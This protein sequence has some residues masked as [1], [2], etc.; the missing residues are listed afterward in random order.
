MIKGNTETVEGRSSQ[1][2]PEEKRIIPRCQSR[3]VNLVSSSHRL[4]APSLWHKGLWCLRTRGLVWTARMVLSRIRGFVWGKGTQQCRSGLVG[5]TT[6]SHEIL[7]LQ[8][9]DWVE[10][11]S[12]QEIRER[13]DQHGRTQGL[14]WMSNMAR[15]CGKR[16]RVYKR[17]ER[18]MLESNGEI[19]RL[20]NTV[21]LEGAI[22]E[23]LYGCDRSCYHFWKEAWLRRSTEG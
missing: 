16:Y 15:F 8:P 18:M 9:G 2:Q 13:L 10:V 6:A 12:E 3:M 19:R 7:N 23:D 17:V 22:C 5:A 4:A 20:K 21:L 1:A 11:R 14:L